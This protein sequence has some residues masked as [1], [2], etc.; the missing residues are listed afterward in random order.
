M[1]HAL[2]QVT[3]DLAHL[4]GLSKHRFR[5]DSIVKCLSQARPPT[6]WLVAT[7]FG[8]LS[9]SCG[10]QICRFRL[11]M[12][13]YYVQHCLKKIKTGSIFPFCRLKTKIFRK[14][15]EKPNFLSSRT[16]LDKNI[17][18]NGIFGPKRKLSVFHFLPVTPERSKSTLPNRQH[19]TVTYA[20]L[21]PWNIFCSMWTGQTGGI[22]LL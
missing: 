21:L 5:K 16:T 17:G 9:I 8:R 11:R 3:P 12:P 2:F 10:T 20:A 15:G 1:S 22:F 13:I 18:K 6:Q 7:Y 19:S 4:P 14:I